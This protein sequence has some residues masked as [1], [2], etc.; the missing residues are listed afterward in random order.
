M[1]LPWQPLEDYTRQTGLR[2]VAE[3]VGMNPTSVGKARERGWITL[4]TAERVCDEMRVHPAEIWS[5]Y[6]DVVLAIEERNLR[7][8]ER[9]NERQRGYQAAMRAKRRAA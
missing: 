4:R 2:A 6:V 5:E 9:H 1:K 3:D 8:R 7:R